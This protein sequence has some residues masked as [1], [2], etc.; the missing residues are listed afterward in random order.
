MDF[1]ATHLGGR[2][3]AARLQLAVLRWERLVEEETHRNDD[4][5]EAH[6]EGLGESSGA[7]AINSG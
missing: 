4:K 7:A 5:A 6:L 1:G 2:V 3:D